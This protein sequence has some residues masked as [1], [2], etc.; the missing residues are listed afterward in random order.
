LFLY[1]NIM[2]VKGLLLTLGL[3]VLLVFITVPAYRL[4]NNLEHIGVIY[5]TEGF[6]GYPVKISAQEIDQVFDKA[7]RSMEHKASS[8]RNWEITSIVTTW[9]A[10]GLSAI[11]TLMAGFH[12]TL[13]E[14][15]PSSASSL[16]EKLNQ[17]GK[18]VRLIGLVAGLV[19]VLTAASVKSKQIGTEERQKA[20]DLRDLITA[21]YKDIQNA[22]SE[23]DARA[24][25]EKLRLSSEL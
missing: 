2:R 25:L 21:S 8:Y 19:T 6:S 22:S 4:I 17:R 12:G 24:V 7:K 20:V 18:T 14:E 9:L 1:I 11:I 10:F 13:R 16:M 3:L 5:R 23:A 15:N